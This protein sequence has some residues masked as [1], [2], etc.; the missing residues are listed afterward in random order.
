MGELASSF[1]Y[2]LNVAAKEYDGENKYIRITD[3]D[4]NTHEFL[5]DNLTSP[6]IELTGADNYKLTE[7]DILFARTGAS[8]GK[9]YIYKNSDGLV[10]YAGFL[11][12]AR[13]KEEYDAEFVFQNTLTGRYNK[14]IAVTSQ[15]SGQ[16]GVNAQEYAE[17]EIKVPKKEEQTKIGT[18]FRNIDHLITLHQRIFCDFSKK[19]TFTWEQRKLREIT[20]LKSA[21]RV[22]KDEWTSNGVP[23]YRSSDVMAAINGTENE[24]AFISEELYE[25]LSKVS[26]KL[27]EGD[28]LVTGGGTVGNPYIV[29]DN[30]P[31]YTKDADLLWIKNKGK[32]H[33]YFLYEFF[34]S[35]TFRSYLGSISHVGTIAHYTITQLS[36]T[37]ICLPSFEEQKEVGEYFQSLDHLITLHQ[38]NPCNLNKFMAFDWEQRKCKDIFDRVAKAVDVEVG[39]VYREIGIRSHGKGLFYKDE[40]AGEGLGNKRVFWVEPNSFI[41]NIVFAWERAVAKTT[42]KEL[43]MIAS[44]RFP[45]YKPKENVADLDY[46]TKFFITHKGKYILEMASPG[47]AGRNKTL[48]QKEFENSTICLPSYEEQKKI[49]RYLEVFDHL[50]TLHHH[51]PSPIANLPDFTYNHHKSCIICVKIKINLYIGTTYD[52]DMEYFG[53]LEIAITYNH[54]KLVYLRYVE[55]VIITIKEKESMPELESVIEQKLI[56]QLVYGES[57]WT[58]RDDLK[59]EEDLWANFRYI[60]EQNNKDRLN[61]EHLS[62]SEFEQ[63]KNQLQFSSFYKAGEWLVGENGKVQVHV[64]R[65]TEKLHL[66]VMNHEH[67]A[68]GTSVYEVIN[69]YSALKSK[70]DTKVV[71]RDRRFDVTLLINGLPMIHIELKNKQHSYMDGFWQIKKYIGE[72]KFTGI[73]SSVQM[74]VVSNGVDTRYFAAA[75]DTELNPKFMSGWVDRENNPVSDYLSFA[76]N[77]LRIPEAHEMIARYTVLDE[78][79]KRLILLRPYQIHAIESIREASKVGK[80][81][82]V[83]HTTGSGK[84]LTSYKATRNLLMDI[85][86]IDKAIFL[87]DRKDL[88]TQTTMAFQAYANND[89]V[90]V[91]ETDNVNDLKKKLKSDDRQ[92]IVTTIQKMQI[93]IGKRLEE[94]TSDYSK[95]KNLKIAF[96]VDECHRA[97]TPKTKRELERFFGRALWYGFTGTPRFAENPYPQMG[98]LPR[99]TE[100]LYGKRLHRYTIQN[101]IHDKAVLGFQVEHNGPKNMPDE[102]DDSIYESEAYMLKVLEVILNKSYHKLGFQNGKGMT[103]EGL[104]TTSSIQRAQKYYEL[105]AKVKNGETSLVIDEKIK[106]VL[107]DFPKFAITYSVTENEEGSH[108]NQEKM[109][110]SLD[111]YNKIFG[112]KYELSQI[113]R[114]NGNLNKR[115][116]RKEAKFKRRSEQLDLVIVVD[117]LLTG[118]DAPCMSTIF[119]DRQPMGPHDLIQAFSRTN[120]IYDKNKTYGQIVTFQAPTLFKKCVDD[121]VKL[122]SAGS[123]GIAILAE[124]NEVEPAFRKA[125]SALKVCAQNPSDIPEMSI[126]EKKTF[127]KMFQVFDSLFAQLKSFTRYNDS[128]LEEYGITEKEYEDYVGHYKNVMEEI[129]EEKEP[130]DD[131][132]G[133]QVDS[134]YELMAYSN[135][136]IDYEYIINLI[137]NI[138]T[139]DEEEEEI[140][141]EERQKKLSEAKQYI[142]ELRKDNEKVADIMEN[143]IVDIEKD[144]TKYRGQSILNIVEN[145][146][147]DCIDKVISDFCNTWYASKTDVMYAAIHYRNG[148]IPNESVIKNTVNYTKYKE[149]QEKILPRYKYY[150][151]MMAELKKTLNEEIKPL[152]M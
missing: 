71:A 8:V 86:A 114:Y 3:I 75:S 48:G 101:A 140:T 122:Y 4:D 113:Q 96:V 115:L 124:W 99:T 142:S 77:V 74:F 132:D 147:Q 67:I 53:Y 39:E 108:A 84:T 9:S 40:I 63:V 123:T 78:D 50:I 145:M 20:E 64:Q 94:G 51:K 49:G 89:L 93:L 141:P 79:A 57:Q 136:K 138:V 22:H 129:R 117:R 104:L 17:F 33:P 56:E 88:D 61:G 103:Y 131:G 107:P 127:A 18:Y 146:K 6:D 2:G 68:G 139:P 80:S 36:D 118:F 32:F 26:G 21:S 110:K 126:K 15:R 91:D 134:D 72:G 100:E 70:T 119:I 24:K 62:D 52:I 83:W 152:L 85:P 19:L 43:G 23:F 150:A 30:K 1:E 98:D 102:T 44:H 29:P 95:I 12:R 151:R 13:I 31:L 76:K 35:P 66:V 73:F 148:Q 34:F 143:L 111:D 37:P 128:M 47:G 69:Q 133:T 27:E 109:Q 97:V 38:R 46:I 16:P 11:I 149:S 55:I 120:R 41:L 5:T 81:G 82:F 14:Y 90:D 7:G 130:G 28:I 87:I 116:A 45:M 25:K 121:A 42:E 106:Q 58:Y 60:L 112:T 125:L 144:G 59:T 54:H 105:L 10:Y 137:Q 92:V 135:T 65:D